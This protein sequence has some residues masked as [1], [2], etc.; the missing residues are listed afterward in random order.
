MVYINEWHVA[1][2]NSKG[3]SVEYIKT[4]D[5]SL[6]KDSDIAI[7]KESIGK[8]GFSANDYRIVEFGSHGVEMKISSPF[9]HRALKVI[10][11]T[12]YTKE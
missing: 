9:L 4:L 2:N 12:I 7:L 10:R 6:L 1:T 5:L 3:V 8:M 11:K